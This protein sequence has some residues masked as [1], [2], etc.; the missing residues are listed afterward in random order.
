MRTGPLHVFFGFFV[1]LF[2]ASQLNIAAGLGPAFTDLLQL[3]TTFS[4]D[5]FRSILDGW[6]AEELTSYRT[7]FAWDSIHPLIYGTFLVLW[8]LVVHRRRPF[9]A[10]G[11]RMIITL[12]VAAPVL[13]YVE[14]AFHLYLEANRDAITGG[15][16]AISG[17]V[18]NL[19]WACGFLVAV[20]LLLASVR[21]LGG[22]P[23]A[24]RAPAEPRPSAGD[25]PSDKLAASKA[26]GPKP[27]K[28][29]AAKAAQT[30]GSGKGS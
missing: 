27:P 24:S 9:S 26:S 28:A 3:Q 25:T 16:V 6:S 15:T 23:S 7:H 8:A 18:A 1:A 4:A 13:D 17:G 20:L 11:V 5:I 19:K 10:R 2:A 21:A 30:T 22:R 14:N 29:G 12:A